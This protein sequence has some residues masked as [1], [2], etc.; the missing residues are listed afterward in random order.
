MTAIDVEA[1]E[2]VDDGSDGSEVGSAIEA[3]EYVLYGGKGGVGKTTMAA[4]TALRSAREGTQTLVV[5]TDPAHSLSDVL[6]REVPAE[7]ARIHA[8]C[9]LFGVEIDPEDA[10][11]LGD[12]LG[13]GSFPG[14]LGFF[15][16]GM[17]GGGLISGEMSSRSSRGDEREGTEGSGERGASMPGADEAAALRLLLRYLDDER[18]ER[19]VIDTAPTGHTLRLF[20]LPDRL[21]ATLDRML[22]LREGLGG[23]F[24]GFG[25]DTDGT[26]GPGASDFSG[27]SGFSDSSDA[28]DGSDFAGFPGFEE[29]G[30]AGSS[31]SG[32]TE[33]GPFGAEGSGLDDLR[34]LSEKLEALEAALTDPERTDF[35]IVVVPERTSVVESRRLLDSLEAFDIPVETIVVNRV[36][37]DVETVLGAD[38][39]SGTEP[40]MGG[41]EEDRPESEHDHGENEKE[42][43]FAAPQPDS[44]SFCRSRLRSQMDVLGEADDLFR[45]RAVKRVPLFATEARG[46]DFL[47]V[48]AACLA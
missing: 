14:G 27:F 15:G 42:D 16:G 31:E 32:A 26:A 34:E 17:A 10:E 19:V 5:S 28:S 41:D 36:M 23:M 37:E 21:D 6:D 1:V 3:P 29:V 7:P 38:N 8:E 43:T 48:V 46:E 35:R 18:F 2:E 40:T 4:A 11:D 30:S 9:P 25:E 47:D 39:E 44:C 12:S 20:E 33:G 45:G 13:A 22:S 24:S